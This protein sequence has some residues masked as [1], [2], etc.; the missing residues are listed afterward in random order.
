MAAAGGRPP[1]I[2]GD[3]LC[4]DLNDACCWACS[5][6]VSTKYQ[7]FWIGLPASCSCSPN[8]V[9][10]L[11]TTLLLQSVDQA[12]LDYLT[13]RVTWFVA[14]AVELSITSRVLVSRS[15]LKMTGSV[16]YATAK[17]VTSAAETSKMFRTSAPSLYQYGPEHSK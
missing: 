16:H 10:S 4:D 17:N 13:R 3:L 2:L 7:G 8:A 11:C 5:G 15:C 1:G 14:M 6:G 12:H 9:L